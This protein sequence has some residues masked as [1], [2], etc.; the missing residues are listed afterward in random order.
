MR[1]FLPLILFL[2]PIS[3]LHAEENLRT[4]RAARASVAPKI[5]GNLEDECWKN[6]ETQGDFKIFEPDWGNSSRDSTEVKII[7]DNKAVYVY[8]MMYDSQPDSIFHELGSR[9]DLVNA[10][11]FAV[12]FDTY[13][14]RQDAFIFVVAASGVQK[15]YKYNDEAFDAVWESAAQI[16]RNGWSVEM[17]IPYSAIRFPST[18]IQTWGINFRRDVFRRKEQHQWAITPRGIANEL[19]KIGTVT[20]IENIKAPV[21]LSLTPYLSGLLARSPVFNSEGKLENYSL[22]YSY[23]AGADVKY[24][25]NDRFTLDVTLLPDFS[26]VQSDNKVKNLGPFEVRY[27]EN[28]F[29]FME[30]ADIFSKGSIF[31]SR[32]IGK[33]PRLYSSIEDS[34]KP[35]ETIEKN[36]IQVKLINAAKVSGRTDK[37]L[38]IGIINAI[39]K[40]EYAILKDSLGRERKILSEP[41][42]NYNMLV[43]DQ[44]FKNNSSFYFSNANT[45][46][47]GSYDDSNVSA[48]GLV[49]TN[50]KNMYAF[51]ARSGLSQHYLLTGDSIPQKTNELGYKYHCGFQKISGNFNFLVERN[52]ISDTYFPSDLGIQTNFDFVNNA[53]AVGYNFLVPKGFYRYWYHSLRIDYSSSYSTGKNTESYYNYNGELLLKNLWKVNTDAGFTPKRNNNYFES[54]VKGQVYLKPKDFYAHLQ[55]MSN[56]R[57]KF[58]VTAGFLYGNYINAPVNDPQYESD[59]ILYF[60]YSNRLSFSYDLNHLYHTANLGWC[61]FDANNEPVFGDR[62]RTTLTN[63]ITGRYLFKLNMSIDLRVRHYWDRAQ[64]NQFYALSDNGELIE[65][66]A[67][68]DFKNFDYN[69]FNVDVVYNWFFAPGSSLSLIYKN[70]IE[71]ESNYIY[72]NYASNLS[73]T[74]NA[75]QTNSV[76]LKLLYY[77]DYL[78]LQKKSSEH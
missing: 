22:S 44:Q 59:L 33:V 61:T 75:A 62:K 4:I 70:N 41:L 78:Y 15:E 76:S 54:R 32:R 66:P 20:G 55:I 38:G 9:D 57:K 5:D 42:A 69:V 35:G 6:A 14:N 34:L 40:S 28:R 46:R 58:I 29:F 37:G 65:N 2:L 27:D 21:R 77:I 13:N 18:A 52:V 56:S 68:T 10:D 30:S 60:R 63:L 53:A 8:A 19:L 72:Y 17:K 45:L 64:Y 16:N 39:T 67:F 47:N 31:Y 1:F 73:N 36:P 48:A 7:Y 49:L 23:G 24:G 43:F 3:V 12:E 74:L 71:N 26:Q 50:K 11:L 51:T 25:L